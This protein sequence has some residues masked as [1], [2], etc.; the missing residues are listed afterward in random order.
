M[1]ILSNYFKY[2][3]AGLYIL[4]P[5]L[6]GNLILSILYYNNIISNS[7][8][9]YIPLGILLISLLL[10]GIYLGNKVDQKGYLEGLKLGLGTIIIFIIF[11]LIFK[12]K[13][14]INSF[15]YYIIILTI[16]II[17]SIIGINKKKKR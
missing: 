3:K 11:S 1:I 8:N 17:G 6:L 10:S 9:S 2:I 14:G 5:L 12:Q 16:S 13:L 15:I 4:I 7:L